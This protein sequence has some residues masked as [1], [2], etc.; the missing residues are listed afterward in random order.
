M[1]PFGPSVH[2]SWA[3]L[4]IRSRP[5]Q[6]DFEERWSFDPSEDMEYDTRFR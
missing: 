1:K 5:E 3:R 2:A 4:L 6:V